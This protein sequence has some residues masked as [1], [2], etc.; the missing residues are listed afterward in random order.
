MSRVRRAL[1]PQVGSGENLSRALRRRVMENPPLDGHRPAASAHDEETR[2]ETRRHSLHRLPDSLRR[3]SARVPLSDVLRNM[4]MTKSLKSLARPK[5]FELL[6]PKFVV[7]CSIQ[8][9]YGRLSAFDAARRGPTGQ[10][11]SRRP[12]LLMGSASVRKGCRS[13]AHPSTVA[14]RASPPYPPPST[15]PSSRSSRAAGA[16]RLA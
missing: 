10:N 4:R 12:K 3:S 1:R 13:P 2:S 11:P 15:V 6:T 7:W 9:S 16:S 5:R 8:L 14:H